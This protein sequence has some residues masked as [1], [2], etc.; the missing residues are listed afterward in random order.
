MMSSLPHEENHGLTM[1]RLK[2]VLIPRC[3]ALNPS[4]KIV[5]DDDDLK[6]IDKVISYVHRHRA[7]GPSKMGGLQCTLQM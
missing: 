5:I 6:H 1:R 4:G 3:I 2:Q 7:R